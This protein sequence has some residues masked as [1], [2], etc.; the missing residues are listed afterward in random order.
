MEAA[1]N[2][3]SDTALW[4]ATFRAPEGQRA[5]AA[6]DDPLAALLAGE[7]GRAI[8]SAFS[9]QEM[10]AWGMVV[11]T[12]AIDRLIYEALSDGVDTVLNLGAGLDARPYR[13]K[14]PEALRWIEVDFPEIVDLKNAKLID[15]QPI[16]R[17]ERIGM[18]L[19]DRSSR[20]E[21]FARYGTASKRILVITEGVISYLSV[22]DASMLAADLHAEPSMHRWIQDF[23]NAGK[24]ALPRGWAKRLHSAPIL[25]EV[26]DWFAFFEKY[27]W[28]SSETITNFEESIRINRP[29]PV[30]FPY[31]VLMRAI[32]K[33]WRRKILGLSG[34]VMM[35]KVSTN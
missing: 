14:L 2:N 25:F 30:D 29:Y 1:V 4:V 34:V 12:S 19:L 13:L 5:D 11:R 23:D 3:V 16:C 7:R 31:G 8:A 21:L 35:Q 18:D 9:R 24:R 33:E 32:P 28:R 17:L 22:Y 27:G 26:K 15:H 10:S 6:F 20:Q